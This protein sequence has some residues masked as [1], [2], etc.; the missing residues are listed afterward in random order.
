MQKAEMGYQKLVI[1][2]HFSFL[3]SQFLFFAFGFQPF[4]FVRLIIVV[5]LAINFVLFQRLVSFGSVAH[6][7]PS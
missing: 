4:P 2:M 3:L 1:E 6:S 5:R 7:S